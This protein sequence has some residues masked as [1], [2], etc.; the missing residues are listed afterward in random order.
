[1]PVKLLKPI[2]DRDPYAAA[3]LDEFDRQEKKAKLAAVGLGNNPCQ[4]CEAYYPANP[5]A[6][7]CAVEING[8]C[9]WIKLHDAA[10]SA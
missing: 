3:V 6:L 5:P 8:G 9:E 2:E 1:M 7:A 10:L 4:G